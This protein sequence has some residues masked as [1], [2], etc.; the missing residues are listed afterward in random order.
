MG[1]GLILVTSWSGQPSV[2]ELEQ[3][4][5]EGV[6]PRTDYVALARLLGAD[7]VDD[8]YMRE[9]ASPL[10]RAVARMGGRAD[11]QVVEALVREGHYR[12]LLVWADGLGFRLATAHK[13]LRRRAKLV[14]ISVRL[15]T[16]KKRLLL[17][18]LSLHTR[19]DAIVNYGSAQRVLA[20]GY[21]VPER[22]LHLLLQPVDERFWRPEDGGDDEVVCAVG[23]EAR[24]Y[25]TFLAAVRGLPVCAEIAVGSSVLGH[26]RDG[27]PLAAGAGAH[28]VRVHR[29]LSHLALRALYARARIVVV[30][31]QDVDYDAGVTAITEAMA[32]GKPLIVTQTH[33]QVDVV[34]NGEAAVLVPPHDP[35][36]LRE[37]II[38]LLDDPDECTRMGRA[39]R[40][41]VEQRHSLDAYV[42]DLARI[43]RE[44][45]S[46]A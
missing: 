3:Q 8:C 32:M 19:I 21:G 38:R 30:P 41:A 24:D 23:S 31:L 14:I 33:G 18:P 2:A 1:D 34:R 12:W 25:D 29:K 13:L 16:P 10:A 4:A 6:R 44:T 7:V 35:S 11:G 36:A 46:S 42:A 43:V 9:H 22:K 28:S 26:S 27:I 39:G 20:A 5:S 15:A 17:G 40:A 37:A 45:V